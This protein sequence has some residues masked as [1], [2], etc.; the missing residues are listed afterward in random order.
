MWFAVVL[1]LGAVGGRAAQTLHQT[2]RGN[3]GGRQPDALGSCA[4]SLTLNTRFSDDQPIPPR[5]SRTTTHSDCPPSVG[6]SGAK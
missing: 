3:A 2:S 4:Y 6:V 5:L 1:G